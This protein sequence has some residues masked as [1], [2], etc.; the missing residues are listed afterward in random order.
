M[1]KRPAL[2][3]GILLNSPVAVST[4]LSVGLL[5]AR[6][7]YFNDIYLISSMSCGNVCMCM[8]ICVCACECQ[9]ACAQPLRGFQCLWL[10][11]SSLR[12]LVFLRSSFVSLTLS[13]REFV[14][15]CGFESTVADGFVH[16]SSC[17]SVL[18]HSPLRCPNIN[19]T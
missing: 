16:M 13:E 5:P 2:P 17:D 11:V 18:V 12:A 9:C 8:C 6:V 14:C 10:S 4:Q 7:I 15:V 19:N 3:I 1:V